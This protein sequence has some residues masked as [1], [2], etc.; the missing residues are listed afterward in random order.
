MSLHAWDFGGQQIYHAT[1]QFFL[2]DRS[3]FVLLWNSRLG[4]EQ[5]KLQ[6]WLDIIKARAPGSPV[7]L[8]ATHIRDRRSTFRSPSCASST[9]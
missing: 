3:L 2:T 9:R 7:I 8:V 6:Y 1:H 5:G 4:W